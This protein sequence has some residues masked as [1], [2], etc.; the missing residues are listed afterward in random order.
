MTIDAEL[1]LGGVRS[2][3]SAYAERQAQASGQ[4][5]H[6]IAT[7]TAGDAEMAARIAAH[8]ERRPAQWITHEV[9]L[10]LAD[11][12]STW[13]TPARCL[14]VDCLGLWLSN[15]LHANEAVFTTER[16]A[17]LDILPTLP[18]RILLVSNEVGLGLVPSNALAR[19]FTAEL[20]WLNQAV[21]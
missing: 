8:R 6:L 3:K 20:G 21:A 14:L 10:H 15:L 17:L 11:A 7:A 19:R 1:I 2:G 16:Q 4:A 5:V 13:A 12:L 18:G 9:P